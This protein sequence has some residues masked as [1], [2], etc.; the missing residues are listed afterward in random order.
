MA[1]A[2]SPGHRGTVAAGKGAKPLIDPLLAMTGTELVIAQQNLACRVTKEQ[3]REV[4]LAMAEHRDPR[5]TVPE[6]D[7]RAVKGVQGLL[8][9]VLPSLRWGCE[10]PDLLDAHLAGAARLNVGSQAQKLALDNLPEPVALDVPLYFVMG[11]RAGAAAAA[12]GISF[13]LLELR[14]QLHIRVFRA[15]IIARGETRFEPGRLRGTE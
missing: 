1:S 13:R 14:S 9:D 11:G 15:R 7:V 12:D 8:K 3:H 6:G 5:L 10:H 2:F 4:L